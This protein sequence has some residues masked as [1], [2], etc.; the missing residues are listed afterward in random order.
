DKK[1]KTPLVWAVSNNDLQ[2]T[3]QI[4]DKK[5]K[6]DTKDNSGWPAIHIAAKNGFDE[7]LKILIENGSDLNTKITQA[8]KSPLMLASEFGHTETVKTLVENGASIN[9]QDNEGSGPLFLAAEGGHVETVSLL[10]DKGADF[11][12]ESKEGIT[13]LMAAAFQ[14]HKPVVELLINRGSPADAR[15]K[16]LGISALWVAAWRGKINIVDYLWQQGAD[17]NVKS[18][19]GE[20]PLIVAVVNNQFDSVRMLL[21][22]GVHQDI[23]NNNRLTAGDIAKKS[24][25]FHLAWL[26]NSYKKVGVRALGKKREDC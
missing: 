9:A 17:V 22:K 19:K 8:G 14:G 26:I 12:A 15:S 4:L 5:P 24:G 11:N 6:I 3:R 16:K 1:G 7:I 25:M 2:I 21:D 18:K 13:P 20:S 23:E 10:L